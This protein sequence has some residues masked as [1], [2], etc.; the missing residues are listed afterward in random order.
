MK[1]YLDTHIFVD[2]WN[3]RVDKMRPLGDFAYELLRET[4]GCKHHLLFSD[5]IVA[6]LINSCGLTEHDIWNELFSDIIRAGKF[7][8]VEITEQQKSEAKKMAARLEI[9]KSDALHAILARDNKAVLV[10]RD[11]HHES[12]KDFVKVLTPEDI[13]GEF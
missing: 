4:I 2:F 13:T 11:H 8:K 10:S 12:V 6:E 5:L 1:L 3:D 7:S 9:P